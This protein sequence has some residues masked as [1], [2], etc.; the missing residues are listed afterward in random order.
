[1][2]N[3]VRFFMRTDAERNYAAKAAR[4]WR[5]SRICNLPYSITHRRGKE[6]CSK[7][8]PRPVQELIFEKKEKL[9]K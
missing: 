1:M 3:L 9:L 4:V 2:N 6:L 7:S 5:R 8:C